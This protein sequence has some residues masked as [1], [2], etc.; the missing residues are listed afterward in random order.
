M[1]DFNVNSIKPHWYISA[2]QYK[3]ATNDELTIDFFFSYVQKLFD[4]INKTGQ[5][6]EKQ[7]FVCY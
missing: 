3:N 4:K 6:R 7:M 2:I 1:N 5:R